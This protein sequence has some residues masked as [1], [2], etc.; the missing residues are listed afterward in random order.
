MIRPFAI[1]V[2]IALGFIGYYFFTLAPHVPATL[3]VVAKEPIIQIQ[4]EK[5]IQMLFTGDL[6]L[7]RGVA[8]HAK[9]V[10]DE[11]LLAGVKEL[12]DGMDAIVPNLEGTITTNPSVASHDDL[13]FTFDPHYAKF[14][15]DEGITVVSLSNNHSDDFGAD[16][17]SQ[18]KT[19]LDAA[20]IASF[21]SPAND[22]DFSAQVKVQ[23][24][25]VCF[26]GY[27]GFI[28]IDPA[29]IAA[30]VARIRPDCDFVVATMHAG[31]EYQPTFTPLQARAAHAFIDAG[32][33]VV[34][35]THP[36]VVEPLE[37]YKG[38]P[39]FYS[40]G[41]FLFDQDFSWPTEHGLAVRISWSKDKTQ[42]TLIPI[43]IQGQ[44]TRV[45][46]D[47][48]DVARTLAALVNANLPADIA[49]SVTDAH[50][51]S[52]K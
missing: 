42:Y 9:A 4:E 19:N 1:I 34:I 26:V 28:N 11:A 23:N 21:G 8:G 22:K 50:S 29:P 31:E 37:I 15:K 45:T 49:V 2:P 32:A 27:E 25:N 12:F 41:N 40:L 38:K 51:F 16:G 43:T 5:P 13:R 46:S 44:E 14:L 6:M 20:G 47:A 10:G 30:E 3:R 36:H 48:D 35:G 17:Y 7:D 18:T 24:K 33:D 39:I 52:V